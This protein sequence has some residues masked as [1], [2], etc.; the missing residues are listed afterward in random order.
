MAA[1]AKN[2]GSKFIFSQAL[3]TAMPKPTTVSNNIEKINNTEMDTKPITKSTPEVIDKSNDNFTDTSDEISKNLKAEVN[4][5]SKEINIE[6]LDFSATD[7]I[8]M[9]LLITP[10]EERYLTVRPIQQGCSM[11][12]FFWKILKEVFDNP[13]YYNMDILKY[14]KRLRSIKKTIVIPKEYKEK[15][16]L[17]AALY[18]LRQ[19]AFIDYAIDRCMKNDEE[20]QKFVNARG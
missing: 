9:S 3:E 11:K 14:N 10:E 12:L 16:K 1:T 4:A 18:G 19:A 13:D 5:K 8:N 6:T 17:E 2:K 20:Y 15:V 7:I